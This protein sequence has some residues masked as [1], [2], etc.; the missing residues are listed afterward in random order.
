MDNLPELEPAR[1]PQPEINPRIPP[2]P[3]PQAPAACIRWLRQTRDDIV[4]E[5]VDCISRSSPHYRARSAE[6]LSMTISQSFAANC[7]AMEDGRTAPLDSFVEFITRLRLEAGFGLS[8]VQKA[9]DM[10][11]VILLPKVVER[12]Q[13]FDTTLALE[14]INAVVSYQIHR[15][16]DQFQRRHEAAIRRHAEQLKKQVLWQSRELAVSERQHKTLVE[17][18]NDGYVMVQEMRIALANRAFCE[19]HQATWRQSVSQ[20]FLDFVAP[21]DRDKVLRVFRETLAGGPASPVLEYRR[22]DS[23]GRRGV[24]EIRARAVDLGQGPVTHRHLP[25]HHPAGGDGAQDARERAPGLRG[26]AHG[27]ALP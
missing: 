7:Q 21:E 19:M 10:F 20:P 13:A 6:E 25:R 22:I 16:S 14:S 15:F 2:L 1:A 4:S 23:Q 3:L 5:W 18:I 8:E 26:A 27:L 12:G 24:T 17:E 9:F 11:R